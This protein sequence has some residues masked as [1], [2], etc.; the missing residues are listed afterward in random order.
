VATSGHCSFAELCIPALDLVG[1]RKYGPLAGIA[2]HGQWVGSTMLESFVVVID[3]V[4]SETGAFAQTG[5]MG[6]IA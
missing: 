4:H 5:L 6:I 1:A 3:A 2:V